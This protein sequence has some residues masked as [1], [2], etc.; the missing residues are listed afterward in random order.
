[1][2]TRAERRKKNFSKIHHKK[3]LAKEIY[4][5]DYYE[6]DGQYSKGKIHCS[7]P[8]CSAK[9][10]NKGRYGQSINYKHS[11]NQKYESMQQQINEYKEIGK[12]EK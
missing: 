9:T 10:N 12:S 2:R 8:L 3:K 1:M 11:E 5:S 6:Y 7:C 4:G